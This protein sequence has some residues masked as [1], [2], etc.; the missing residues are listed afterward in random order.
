M[1][2]PLRVP[3][4]QAG[5]PNWVSLLSSL[6]KFRMRALKECSSGPE[7]GKGAFQK[8]FGR[9]STWVATWLRIRFV[10]IGAT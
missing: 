8:L 1:T 2:L 10:E 3:K 5:M 4:G 7:W 9:P 6:E